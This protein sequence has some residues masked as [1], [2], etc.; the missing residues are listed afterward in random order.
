M[1]DQGELLLQQALELPRQERAELAAKL[2]NSINAL[3]DVEG[4]WLSTIEARARR[5]VGSAIHAEPLFP[6]SASTVS[7]DMDAE[8]DLE[9]AATAYERQPGQASSLLDEVRIALKRVRR[10]P[11]GFGLITALPATMRVRRVFLKQFPYAIAFMQVGDEIKVLALI[12]S[13]RPPSE[14]GE[15]SI[16]A[17]VRVEDWLTEQGLRTLSV[18]TTAGML[19]LPV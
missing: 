15:I 3:A 8:V 11:Y 10:K 17:L 18:L 7:F 2:V 14:Q 16:T 12:H 19:G 1:T 4:A 6:T 5:A 9:C 13:L